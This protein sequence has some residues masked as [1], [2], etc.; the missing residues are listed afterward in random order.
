MACHSPTEMR[1]YGSGV[2]V[3]KPFCPEVSKR[4]ATLAWQADWGQPRCGAA[5]GEIKSDWTRL[6][7]KFGQY[8]KTSTGERYLAFSGYA[9][10]KRA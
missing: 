2:A 10:E 1:F 5:A 3:A 4:G 9:K 7:D 8:H 6:T